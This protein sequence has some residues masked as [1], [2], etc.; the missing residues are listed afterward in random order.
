MKRNRVR[1]MLTL[2]PDLY[3]R[4]KALADRM[5]N[6]SVSRIVDDLL[7]EIL[8][9]A[10]TASEVEL[11]RQWIT[12]QDRLYVDSQRLKFPWEEEKDPPGE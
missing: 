3:E 9:W 6:Y 11:R 4:A 10:E 1:V 7:A 12:H 2:D 5:H 8:P